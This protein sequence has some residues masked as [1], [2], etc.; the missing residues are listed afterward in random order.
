MLAFAPDYITD[1]HGDMLK[2]GCNVDLGSIAPNP[3]LN[4]I[5]T[6]VCHVDEDDE[7]LG[8]VPVD[9]IINFG[10][11]V[12][13]HPEG[14]V[15]RL[16]NHTLGANIIEAVEKRQ[17]GLGARFTQIALGSG[18]VMEFNPYAGLGIEMIGWE[19][20]TTP[21]VA[22]A[23]FSMTNGVP[24]VNFTPDHVFD[25]AFLHQ[26]I[27]INVVALK[28]SLK[29]YTDFAVADPT[30]EADYC[31]IRIA[32]GT[33]A[34]LPE[35]YFGPNPYSD[36]PTMIPMLPGLVPFAYFDSCQFV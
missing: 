15:S 24:T 25:P 30:D 10:M 3:Y 19:T 32:T 16:R 11:L 18:V 8:P 29:T 31:D 22:L 27:K 13:Y 20:R 9:E 2:G 26:N 4:G 35:M 7:L 28:E 5:P 17:L 1:M 6:A 21:G 36:N 33:L 14:S 12:G 34:V 23:V